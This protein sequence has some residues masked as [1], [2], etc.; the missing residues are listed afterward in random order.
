VSDKPVQAR[1]EKPTE[2]ATILVVDDS[3]DYR[4]LLKQILRH[5][6]YEVLF[7]GNGETALRLCRLHR[8]VI[9][10]VVTDVVMPGMSG[11][12]LAEKILTLRPNIKVLFISAFVQDTALQ[13]RSKLRS[14]DG[15]LAKPFPPERLITKVQEMLTA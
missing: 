13:I 12:E 7:A 9:H 10:L 8:G 3:D 2:P 11:P 6:G 1:S 14:V 5:Q 15:F 4:D